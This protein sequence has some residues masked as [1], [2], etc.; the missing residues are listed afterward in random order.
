MSALINVF[1][2]LSHLRI[3]HD[4]RAGFTMEISVEEE[5]LGTRNCWLPFGGRGDTSVYYEMDRVR[6][7]LIFMQHHGPTS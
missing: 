7:P 5:S 2:R 4:Q 3:Y 6:I 1:L